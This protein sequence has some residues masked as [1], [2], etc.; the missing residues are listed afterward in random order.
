M[1]KKYFTE[2]E[3]KTARSEY[4]KCYYQKNK[5]KFSKYYNDNKEK[6]SEYYQN[7]KEDRLDY[8]NEY[9]KNNKEDRL[10]YQNDYRS[11]HFGR[12]N[13]LLNGYR[14]ADK[15]RNSGECTLTP[16]WI[17]NNIFN[18]QCCHYCDETDWTKLGVDRKD[19]SLPHTPDNCVPCCAKCNAKKKGMSYD[20]FM[21][22]I[23]RL[24]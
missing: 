7:N 22:M 2:E 16:E 3:R 6:I 13:M 10:K 19:S 14:R 4:N 24:A 20:E 23:G 5:G 1:K 11:T 17:V 12:A 9:Y 18:G 15:K 21:Q 8:Q